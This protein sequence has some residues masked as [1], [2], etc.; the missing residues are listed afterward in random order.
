[1]KNFLTC[2]LLLLASFSAFSQNAVVTYNTIPDLLADHS[3]VTDEV[4]VVKGYHSINDGGGGSFYYVSTRAGENDGGSVLNGWVRI[5]ENHVSPEMWGAWHDGIHDDANAI[6]GAILYAFNKRYLNIKTQPYEHIPALDFYST[7]GTYS[8]GSTVQLLAGIKY[9][10]NNATLKAMNVI[11]FMVATPPSA[12][13]SS[14]LL[15]SS[16]YYNYSSDTTYGQMNINVKNLVID[17][18]GLAE[19]GLLME[20]SV[21]GSVDNVR[22]SAVTKKHWT[23]GFYIVSAAAP[24]G[25]TSL[26]IADI[27][28][29]TIYRNA[30]CLIYRPAQ[31]RYLRGVYQVS[32]SSLSP[33]PTGTANILIVTLTGSLCE[34]VAV[35]DLLISLPT[36]YVMNSNEF[37][38][39]QVSSNFNG[40]GM[41][42]GKNYLGPDF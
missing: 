33:S 32:G 40:L 6:N 24:F 4:Y 27:P 36:G 26:S 18:N 9:D 31:N 37:S 21:Q 28:A 13:S 14:D 22:I 15:S 7:N 30:N 16:P 34:N 39:S 41:M 10:F 42:A 35:G 20:T 1:M 5:I 3:P 23:D 38:S 19:N 29:D 2:L 12:N 11:P 25:S 17:G 8:I